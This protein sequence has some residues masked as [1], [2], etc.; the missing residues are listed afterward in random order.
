MIIHSTLKIHLSNYRPPFSPAAPN[1]AV[2]TINRKISTSRYHGGSFPAKYNK[3][4]TASHE[5]VQ[6]KYSMTFI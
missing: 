1:G 3:N 4:T 5:S 2:K 6:E